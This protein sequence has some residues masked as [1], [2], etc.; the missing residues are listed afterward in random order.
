MLENTN[1]TFQERHLELPVKLKV[2]L[3]IEEI[4]SK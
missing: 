4:C 1:G 3:L 2:K